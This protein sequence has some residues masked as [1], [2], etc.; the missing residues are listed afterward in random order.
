MSNDEQEAEALLQGAQENELHKAEA[1]GDSDGNDGDDDDEQ[2]LED[3]VADAF[4][5]IDDG[6]KNEHV[7]TRDRNLSALF[8]G[9]DEADRLEALGEL[10]AAELDE[11]PEDSQAGVFRHLVRYAIA[12]L[13]EELLEAGA[14]GLAAYEKAKA[15][16]RAEQVEKSGF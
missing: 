1:V 13:D 14:D 3:A 9:L 4:R 5:A 11:D 6:E 16:E 12:D 7:A 10:V 2:S 8:I 15:Q